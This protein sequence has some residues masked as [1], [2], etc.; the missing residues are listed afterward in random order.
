MDISLSLPRGKKNKRS[1]SV[2]DLTSP[3]P[4]PLGKK[5]KS[6][7]ASKIIDLKSSSL[8]S[9]TFLSPSVLQNQLEG[10]GNQSWGEILLIRSSTHGP[11]GRSS[12][13]LRI[14]SSPQS[15]L[16][17]SSQSLRLSRL[18]WSEEHERT[19]P[20]RR[21]TCMPPTPPEGAS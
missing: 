21:Q 16:W 9:N 11:R 15:T 5:Q 19:S 12:S 7:D 18:K 1:F 2:V 13:H 4:E 8:V 10:G 3:N 14:K 6:Q 17:S 20:K